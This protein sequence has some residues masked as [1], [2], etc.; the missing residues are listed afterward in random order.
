[1]NLFIAWAVAERLGTAAKMRAVVPR[2]GK[3]TR[4]TGYQTCWYSLD[5]LVSIADEDPSRSDRAHVKYRASFYLRTLYRRKFLA[6]AETRLSIRR[7]SLNFVL[8]NRTFAGIRMRGYT[9]PAGSLFNSPIL[10]G[11]FRSRL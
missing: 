5:P 6:A 9:F 3:Q 8:S 4:C 2:L 10:T 7:E 11:P 1:M